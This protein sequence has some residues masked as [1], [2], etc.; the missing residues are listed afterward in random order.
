MKL[1][2]TTIIQSFIH[3]FRIPYWAPK[4]HTSSFSLSMFDLSTL[5][6]EK[7]TISP[8]FG[9]VK[10]TTMCKKCVN[11][12]EENRWMEEIYLWFFLYRYSLAIFFSWSYVHYIDVDVRLFCFLNYFY[13]TLHKPSHL[14]KNEREKSNNIKPNIHFYLFFF[15]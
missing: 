15:W 14:L 12:W 7:L 11:I 9:W 10:F 4:V 6:R 1:L 3:S 5:W 8:W 2:H 13:F